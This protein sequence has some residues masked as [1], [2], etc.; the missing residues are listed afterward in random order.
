M[1]SKGLS[2]FPVNNRK[3]NRTRTTRQRVRELILRQR[4]AQ[5]F[6]QT[7]RHLFCNAAYKLLEYG[8]RVQRQEFLDNS[9]FDEL[10]AFA[11][12]IDVI[13]D[14]NEH[15][16]EYFEEKD[17]G[18]TIGFIKITGALQT[19]AA[20]LARR[21]AAGSIGSNWALPQNGCS[22]RYGRWARSIHRNRDTRNLGVKSTRQA[23]QR[24]CSAVRSRG[25]VN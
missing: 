22:R 21:S 7:E 15:V 2:C 4:L 25:P 1:R 13:R 19:P 8:C 11:D 3:K 20:L 14:M 9:L 16:I 24:A 10:N 6:F 17:A 18:R 23:M 12:D 5:Q